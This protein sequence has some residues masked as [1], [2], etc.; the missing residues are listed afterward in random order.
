MILMSLDAIVNLPP[1][2][3]KTPRSDAILLKLP[4]TLFS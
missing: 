1:V 2:T 3:E 4:A